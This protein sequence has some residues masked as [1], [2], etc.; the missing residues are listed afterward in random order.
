MKHSI[1]PAWNAHGVAD[2]ILAE[3]KSPITEE[4]LD[5]FKASGDQII[6]SNHLMS[7]FDQPVAEV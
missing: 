4:M 1:H 7:I 3:F 6:K 2:V 5:V